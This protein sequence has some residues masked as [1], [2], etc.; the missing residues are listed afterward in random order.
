MNE[1]KIR[2]EIFLKIKEIYNLQKARTKF[3]PGKT[4]IHYSGRVYNEKEMIVAVD[5][6]LDFYLT[7]GKRGLNFEKKFA[8]I[9]KTKYTILV[10]SGSSA[11]LVAVSTICSKNIKNHLKPGD[12]VITPAVTFPTTVNPIIQNNLIPVFVDVDL[13]TYNMN[14]ELMKEATTKETKAIVIPHTLGNP[15]DMKEVMDF[16]KEKN[17]FVIEDACDALGSKLNGKFCGTFGDMGTFSFYPAHH[18]TMGE[19]GAIITNDYM[20]AKTARSIRDWGRDCFCEPG[21]TNPNGA[22]G[23]RFNF[24]INGI[25]YDHKY[26]Y[27]N[28]GYNLKVL[29]IQAAIGLAQLKKLPKFEKARKK[30]F[31][32]LYNILEK[33][34]DFFILPKWLPNADPS[35]FAFPITIKENAPFNREELIRYLESK[36]IETR[37]LFAGNIIRQPAYSGIKYRI[38]KKLVNSDFIMKNTFFIGVYPGITN[39][40]MSYIETCFKNFLSK[41]K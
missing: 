39:E 4:K 8:K 15:N 28:I 11:N 33:Y 10:N 22:C 35:W 36:Q 20:L 7:F 17:L 6:I 5:A 9:N 1:K 2:K 12:E 30:N 31:R 38:H 32:I 34:E 29:D 21:D 16:A 27:S 25:P 23:N 3:I 14:I 37:L 13:G 18:I 26:I 24:K 41:F 19:G 40:M